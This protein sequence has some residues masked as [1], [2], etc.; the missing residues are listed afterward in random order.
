MTLP[1][2]RL[3]VIDESLDKRLAHQLE[4]RGRR[5]MSAERL[6]LLN[7]LDPAVLRALDGLNDTWVLVTGDDDMPGEHAGL[8][9]SLGCTIATIDGRRLAEWGREQW[10]K[11]IVHRWAHV[12]QAQD[13]GTI[14]RYGLAR[15]RPWTRRRGR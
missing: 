6:G 4:Q 7:M 8:I 14:V 10:K 12:I 5:A 9:A 15:P 11:E 1:P 3:L 2:D 13:D